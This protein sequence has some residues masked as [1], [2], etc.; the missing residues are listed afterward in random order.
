MTLR[1]GCI[2]LTK[3]IGR[4]CLLC[5]CLLC[6]LSLIA[7]GPA[8][9]EDL[10]VRWQSAARQ[11]VVLKWKPPSKEISA[12]LEG[13]FTYAVR[14]E[15]KLC[16]LRLL[17]WDECEGQRLDKRVSRDPISDVITL[18]SDRLWDNEGPKSDEFS[19]LTDALKPIGREIFL[20]QLPKSLRA[21]RVLKTRVSSACRG[22]SSGFLDRIPAILTLGILSRAPSPGGDFDSGWTEF[23]LKD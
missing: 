16:S 11:S 14:Y 20:I 10:N 13:G 6:S 2:R 1:I 9:A 23:S 7:V 5:L 21:K 3:Q 8:G 15:F 4:L 17:W 22:Q 19:L 18:K 12:C